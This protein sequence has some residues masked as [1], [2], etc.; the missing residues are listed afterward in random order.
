MSEQHAAAEELDLRSYFRPVW[1]RKWIILAIV[2][3]AAGGTYFLS[4][5]RPKSYQASTKVYLQTSNPLAVLNGIRGAA[6]S[7]GPV[8]PTA[9]SL[10]DAAQLITSQQVT[11]AVARRLHTR[12]YKAGSVTAAPDSGTSFVTITATSHRPKLAARLANTYALAFLASSQQTVRVAARQA[13]A[14]AQTQLANVPAAAKN[15]A[16]SASSTQLLNLQ[17][18]VQQYKSLILAPSAGAQQIDPATPPRSPSS[19]KPVRDAIFGGIVGLVLGVIVAF[20]LELLDRRLVRVST[21]ESIYGRPVLAVLPHVRNPSPRAGARQL[22]IPA[23]FLEELRS[24]KVMLR[25]AGNPDPP[26]TIMITSALPREGKSTITRD[27]ALVYADAGERVLVIDADLRRPSMYELFN[28]EAQAGLVQVLQGEAQLAEAVATVSLNP[29]AEASTNGHTAPPTTDGAAPAHGV[30]SVLTH[31]ERPSNP[32]P[33]LSSE[34]MT[35]LL[36]EASH[37]YD[38]VLVDTPPVLTVA[39]GVPLLE[40]VDS[41]LLVA[42]LGYVTRQVAD[43]LNQLVERLPDITIAGVVANDRREKAGDEGYGSY[44]RYGYGYYAT[45]GKNDRKGDDGAV[46]QETPTSTEETSTPTEETPTSTEE[47]PTPASS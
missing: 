8:T 27:L 42:R 45:P 12:V 26:R 11:G 38:V 17:Q 16:A 6:A 15:S 30:V 25:L 2:V 36:E 46:K 43:H 23:P 39:D 22:E 29:A 1:R 3:I 13:L 19:P 33:L 9:Q 20:C 41:V 10:N 24:L 28:V 32:E 14:A 37:A 31:G 34:R 40:S 35:A 47:T 7:S 21:V 18:Q 5:R 4:S 44:G